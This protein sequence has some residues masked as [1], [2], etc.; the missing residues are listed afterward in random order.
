MKLRIIADARVQFGGAGGEFREYEL[1]AGQTV[2]VPDGDAAFFIA[3]GYAEK[4][5]E[6]AVKPR[7]QRA[8][9]Q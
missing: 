4:P 3:N 6:R 7:G 1:T 9:K 5:V 8:V 2:D